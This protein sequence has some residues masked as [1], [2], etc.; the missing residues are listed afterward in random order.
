MAA[1]RA[2]VVA[3]V[4]DVGR[5]IVV[6]RAAADAV[7]RVGGVLKRRAGDARDRRRRTSAPVRAP[8]RGLRCEGRRR[9]APARRRAAWRSPRA[10]GR[11]A[12]RARRSGRA[13]RGRGSRAAASSAAR[14]ARPRAERPRRPRTGRARLRGRPAG[15]MRRRRRGWRLRCCGR[16]ARASGGSRRPLR[17]SWSCRWSPRRARSPV[18][19]GR[20]GRRSAPDRASTRACPA[21][22]CRRRGRRAGTAHRRPSAPQ[23]RGSGGGADA[24]AH[25]SDRPRLGCSC[26][27]SNPLYHYW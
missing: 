4:P 21:G 16:P 2:A 17:S 14:A 24:R 26:K 1:R 6:R 25:R 15:P 10:S 23:S 9:S 22:S 12:A 7:L 18:A 8:S 13:G 3:E 27:S 20:R 11:R 5:R 19:D